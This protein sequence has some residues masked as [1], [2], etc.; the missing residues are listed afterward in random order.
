MSRSE[1]WFP[2]N[3]FEYSWLYR[4]RILFLE[5]SEISLQP[6][7]LPVFIVASCMDMILARKQ[8]NRSFYAELQ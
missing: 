6:T 1:N 3:L 2:H 7:L 5:G 4:P 8:Q